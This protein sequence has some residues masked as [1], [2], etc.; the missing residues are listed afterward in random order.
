MAEKESDNA[1]PHAIT[2]K[3]LLKFDRN[4]LLHHELAMSPFLYYLTITTPLI[5][6]VLAIDYYM[7]RYAKDINSAKIKK[8]TNQPDK[9]EKVPPIIISNAR[10]NESE[11][12]E[13]IITGGSGFIG[14]WIARFLIFRG[15]TVL[16][17]TKVTVLDIAALPPDLTKYGVKYKKVDM[18]QKR[19]LELAM[20][21]TL[22]RDEVE[23]KSVNKKRVVVFH[24]AAIQK[25]F[26]S[27]AVADLNVRIAQN[28][29]DVIESVS[30]ELDKQGSSQNSI[31]IINISD[32]QADYEPPKWWN[33]FQ[34]ESWRSTYANDKPKQSRRY[35]SS[36]AQS[37]AEAENVLMS[38]FD[39]HTSNETS[40]TPVYV[41]SLKIHGLVTGYY[42]DSILNPGL[43]YG[44]LIDHA[45][46]I[47]VS[48]IHVEDVCRAALLAENQLVKLHQNRS[49][50]S[51]PSNA[52]NRSLVVSSGQTTLFGDFMDRV[53]STGYV[54][55]IR[56]NPILVLL[57]SHLCMPLILIS[58]A[59]K[60]RR[61]DASIFSGYWYTLTK[62]RFNTIQTVQLVNQKEIQRTEKAI[63]FVAT[64][65]LE[66]TIAGLVNDMAKY[67]A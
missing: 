3:L 64:V 14:S 16:P 66:E 34:V 38:S 1:Q 25:H 44:G 23:K 21:E 24:C 47:P 61:R 65:S 52:S 33:L 56:I 39:W 45:W 63:G 22:F 62:D 30:G 36:Y 17:R 31:T 40:K 11:A 50:L 51:T 49:K 48:F 59:G 4:Y 12:I 5:V 42:H 54:R 35:L 13:Y 20:K 18:L 41:T 67:K 19:D 9:V 32:A 60:W 28:M 58:D 27:K 10:S 7:N 8:P 26:V 37:Q 43:K 15:V 57:V 46:S 29:V 2:H 55:D 53:S 6:Y